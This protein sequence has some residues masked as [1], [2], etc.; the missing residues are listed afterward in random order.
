MSKS[1]EK[2]KDYYKDEKVTG[3]YDDQR[4]GNEYR[5]NKR[6]KELDLFLE[7]LDKQKGEKVVEL[8][9][10]SGF[11]A[12]H[13]GIAT[14][15]DTSA[16]MLKITKEKNP[17][18]TAVEADMFKLPFDQKSFDKVVTMR[19]WNHLDK[20]ELTKALLEAHRILKKGG[21]LVFDLEEANMLR[22][23]ANFM[24]KRV[25]KTTGYKLYRYSLKDAIIL[26]NNLGFRIDKIEFLKHKIGRQLVFRVRK[27]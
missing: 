9:C 17:N 3:T 8:G 12:Q 27:R 1:T 23:I 21:T 22:A 13:L 6:K 19:V 14:A 4:E 26:I 16:K 7:L 25:F 2:F 18:I 5:K 24:Y 20:I 15:I 11:L 10:S